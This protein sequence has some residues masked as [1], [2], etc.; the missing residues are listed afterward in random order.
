MPTKLGYYLQTLP[1][2]PF[3]AVP[4][5]GMFFIEYC[6]PFT[7]L[8]G[9]WPTL[10]FI[11][12]CM[13]MLAIQ[14]GGNY[15]DFQLGFV[16]LATVLLQQDESSMSSWP[17][18]AEAPLRITLL[19]VLG[20]LNLPSDSLHQGAW[21]VKVARFSMLPFYLLPWR[22]V[23]SYGVFTPR[24][25][26]PLED[27]KR[28][29]AI[30]EG[31][32]DG[33]EWRPIKWR[34]ATGGADPSFIAP[35]HPRIDHQSFYEQTLFRY[36]DRF[37]WDPYTP[38]SNTWLQRL[39]YRLMEPSCPQSLKR[40]VNYPFETPANMMRVRRFIYR[41]APLGSPDYYTIEDDPRAPEPFGPA[42]DSFEI[43]KPDVL[44]FLSDNKFMPWNYLFDKH[45]RQHQEVSNGKQEV[46][47]APT[48]ARK[49]LGMN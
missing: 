25:P 22:M 35:Y 30:L 14:A 20:L 4:Y 12:I 48:K 10:N 6:L 1:V 19:L 27:G 41:F 29:V 43:P 2:W 39:G 11:C 21:M 42:R 23:S 40:L 44:W 26:A 49:L 38:Q 16:A 47:P 31:S 37:L 32:L 13:L 17:P 46:T 7:F 45:V 15:G 8:L 28:R 34:F 3:H 9:Y 5:I 36:W 24:V 33:L 18:L